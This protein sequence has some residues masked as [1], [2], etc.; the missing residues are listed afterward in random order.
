M[1]FL[2]FRQ[3]VGRQV[4]AMRDTESMPLSDDDAPLPD[5]FEAELVAYLDGE[6]DA[7]EARRVELRLA[8]DPQARAKA[9]AL[10]KTYDL[11]DYLPRPEPSPD[12]TTR[13]LHKL[14]ATAAP[15][16]PAALPKPQVPINSTAINGVPSLSVPVALSGGTAL[17]PP[18]SSRRV[19]WVAGLA[20]S[21]MLFA[22]AGYLITALVHPRLVPAPAARE[23][24]ADELLLTERGLIERLPLYVGVDNFDF[25]QELAKSDYFGADPTLAASG[26]MPAPGL[27]SESIPISTFETLTAA[28]KGLPPA[29]KQDLRELDKQLNSQDASIRDRLLRIL[30][31]Y[32]VWLDNLPEVERR[33]VLSAP[34]PLVRLGVIR[35]IRERQWLNRLPPPQ[36]AELIGLDPTKRGLLIQQWKAEEAQQRDLWAFAHKRAESLKTNRQLWP[37]DTESGRKDIPEFMRTTFRTDDPR[38]SRF[39]P[40]DLAQYREA[41]EA[42]QKGNEW[43][44]YGKTVYD[45][46]RKYETLPEPATGEPITTY[47]QLGLAGFYFQRGRAQKMTVGLVGKWP[48]FALALNAYV[49]SEKSEKMP[50]LPPLGPA[51]VADFPES[52]REFWAK[53]LS[54]KLT[55][56]ERNR[57][58]MLENRWPEFPREFIALARHYDLSVPGIL[59]PG[60]PR[61]WETIYGNAWMPGPLIRP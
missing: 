44:W 14:P 21:V 22:L 37:F 29:R 15:S 28:F 16:S 1:P 26:L 56:A 4:K 23:T 40:G 7:A 6:L 41:L 32:A 3:V 9:S 25:V 8:S 48:D 49:N 34:T 59:L 55:G 57:L 60:S 12:F 58:R 54:P 45:L 31:A 2:R 27:E 50:P 24:A 43:A 47:H 5:P 53:H 30:E 61:K 38:R 33:G 36:Q 13:T 52:I 46:T 39:S 18:R 10:K 51:R 42:A 35:D 17:L 19:V 11:L 20:I